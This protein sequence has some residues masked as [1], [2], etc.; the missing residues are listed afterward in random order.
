[1]VGSTISRDQFFNVFEGKTL[2]LTRKNSE[3]DLKGCLLVSREP[4]KCRWQLK[5]TLGAKPVQLD[6]TGH[7]L[8][9]PAG[10]Q[11]HYQLDIMVSKIG[12]YDFPGE[13]KITDTALT[14]SHA[15]YDRFSQTN[16]YSGELV[17]PLPSAPESVVSENAAPALLKWVNT[18]SL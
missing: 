18:C 16:V 11:G 3:G 15:S 7:C 13:T 1:M 5:G 6:F 10:P 2:E 17:S 9:D 8:I 4:G 14:P 12:I